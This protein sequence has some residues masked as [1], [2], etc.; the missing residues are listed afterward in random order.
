MDHPGKCY[1][2]LFFPQTNFHL[3][4]QSEEVSSNM[5]EEDNDRNAIGI[6]SLDLNFKTRVYVSFD[7]CKLTRFNTTILKL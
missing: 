6:P 1:S 4:S 3:V 2:Q 7:Y 5:T